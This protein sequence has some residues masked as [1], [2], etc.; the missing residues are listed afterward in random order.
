MPSRSGCEC[1]CCVPR[2]TIADVSA[3]TQR[4]GIGGPQAASAV[5]AAFGIVPAPFE[6]REVRSPAAVTLLGLNG[7]RF[8]GP[9]AGERS[10]RAGRVGL[11]QRD[12]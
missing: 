4:I 2:S 1:T 5:E 6:A 8:R 12:G 7:N 9:R 3:D 11:A 10:R